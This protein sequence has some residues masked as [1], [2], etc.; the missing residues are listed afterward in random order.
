MSQKFKI[1]KDLEVAAI[2]WTATKSRL[3]DADRL[4]AQAVELARSIEAGQGRPRAPPPGSTARPS[5]SWTA[6]P[7]I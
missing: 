2:R 5:K 7:P 4:S 1:I 3:P 6:T